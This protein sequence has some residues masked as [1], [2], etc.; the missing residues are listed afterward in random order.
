MSET[1]TRYLIEG[2]PGRTQFYVRRETDA[3]LTAQDWPGARVTPV[4][5]PVP[6]ERWQ[7]PDPES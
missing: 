3:V 6:E 7:P 2:P 5:V 1:T 4:V